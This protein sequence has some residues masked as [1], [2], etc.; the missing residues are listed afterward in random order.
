M[1][2]DSAERTLIAT[3]PYVWSIQPAALPAGLKLDPTTGTIHGTPLNSGSFSI[4]VWL[5]DSAGGTACTVLNLEIGS[6]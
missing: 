5:S 6:D 1:R 3:V 4:A 2:V